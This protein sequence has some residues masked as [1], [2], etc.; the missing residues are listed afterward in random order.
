MAIETVGQQ[1]YADL[2]A[3]RIKSLQ[4]GMIIWI[5]LFCLALICSFSNNLLAIIVGIVAVVYAVV[6]T[7]GRKAFNSK[8][9][10]IE[11]KNEFYRQIVAPDVLELK[12]EQLLVA[13]D[14]VIV[15][16]ADV[17]IYDLH[18]MEKVEVGKQGNVKKTL[19]L[20]EPNGKRHAILSTIRGMEDR[21][22][23]IRCIIDCMIGLLFSSSSWLTPVHEKDLVFWF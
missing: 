21:K 12:E 9:D 3:K 22:R 8:L 17:W 4:T 13:K 20:T 19:F 5:S 7:K 1:K 23:L 10:K 6:N 14:Y 16:D 11:D 15:V 18:H 2:T